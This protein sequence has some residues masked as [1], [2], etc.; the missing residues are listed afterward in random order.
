M[1]PPQPTPHGP[2]PTV[3][4]PS[5]GA[6]PASSSASTG[7]GQRS[8]LRD[9]AALFAE[10]AKREEAI[11]KEHAA[12]GAAAEREGR[13]LRAGVEERFAKATSLAEDDY[14]GA[15]AGIAE[16]H[17][18][19]AS[20]LKKEYEAEK[21]RIAAATELEERSAV[22][23]LKDRTWAAE[24]I[25]EGNEGKPRAEFEAVRKDV[26]KRLQ[27]HTNIEGAAALILKEYRQPIQPGEAGSPPPG[28]T[29]PVGSPQEQYEALAAE[30]QRRTQ[31]LGSR[32]L[33][34]FFSNLVVPVVVALLL[35][36]GAAAA[37][38]WRMAWKPT[39]EV[40][41]AGGG[42]L[43]LAAT[44]LVLLARASR[45]GVRREREPLIWLLAATRAAA[46]RW[47]AYA[48][49][50]RDQQAA[51]LVT[52]R[53]EEVK[54]AREKYEPLVLAAR[55][56]RAEQLAVITQSYTTQRAELEGWR[57]TQTASGAA[58]RRD[59][60]EQSAAAQRREARDAEASYTRQAQEARE[61]HAAA[62]AD[63]ESWWAAGLDRL[64]QQHASIADRDAAR[65]PSWSDPSWR[66]WRGPTGAAPD[67]PEVRF[68]DITLDLASLPGGLPR[69]PS[70]AQPASTTLRLPVELALP[71]HA[72]VFL[73][74]GQKGAGASA[75]AGAGRAESIRLLR[76]LMLRLLLALPPGKAR[77]TIIDPVGLGESFA[78]FMHLA[79]YEEALVGGKIWTEARHIEQRLVDLTE[80]MENVIQKYLRNEFRTIAEYNAQA[81]EIAEPY[82]FLVIADFPANFNEQA[83]ARLAAVCASGARCGV[84]TLIAM[85]A[86]QPTPNGVQVSDLERNSTRL[87]FR[88][89]RFVL[90]DKDFAQ[91]PLRVDEPPEEDT[92]NELVHRIGVAAKDSGRVQVPFDLIAPSPDDL[93]SGD[94]TSDLRVPLGRAGA[95][96][97]QYLTLGRGT[98]Q[99]M[100]IAGKTGSG[101]STLL[102]TI[103]TNLAMWFS[104]DEV[105][106]YLVDFKKGVEFKSYAAHE[107]PHARAVAIESD[108]EFGLS[109]LQRLDVELKRRG[110]L[111]RDLGVQDLAGFRRKAAEAG[112]PYSNEKLPRTLLIID[113]FQEFFTEDDKLAQDAT[114]L[115][116]RLVRQG[117]AFGIHILLGSQT[118]SGAYNLARS[119]MGQMGVRIAL[120]CSEADSYLILSEDNAAA[121]LLSRPGEAIYN[122]ASGLVEGN[123]PFQIA[124]L[125]DEQRDRYLDRV[126]AKAEA[127]RY[128]TDEPQS[129][130]EGNVP[131]D[132][133]RNRPLVAATH[134][135]RPAKSPAAVRIW[136]GD[137][138]AIKDPTAALL[139]RQT[140]SN[141]LIAGQ[142]DEA[143][144]A[145]MAAG[146]IGIG[147]QCSTKASVYVIDS[148]PPDAPHAGYL[149]RIAATLPQQVRPV[150]MRDIGAAMSELAAELARRQESATDDH[151]PVFLFVHGIQRCR[152]LRKAED[153]FSFSSDDSGPKPDKQLAEL[154][155]EGPALGMHTIVWCDTAGNAS[156]ALDR[157]GLKEFDWRALFQMSSTDSSMLIDTP[158][159]GKLGLHRALLHSE[160]Q[161]SAEK[162]RPYAV[163]DEAWAM[164]IGKHFLG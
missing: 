159:A 102:H 39:P 74:F 37:A 67:A 108:R 123:S 14:R 12:A 91:L 4:A 47:L 69:L 82:R 89:G 155:R 24:T 83:A 97:L 33:P 13:A 128:H 96:K 44:I 45:A 27:E 11:Q 41:L 131:S 76:T 119:T 29:D 115:L 104:P 22:K 140:A 127:T 118:L 80:H 26:E 99:H 63:L 137:A 86:R 124:W 50:K 132:L 154:L 164:D 163:P 70:L 64:Q 138:I 51:A 147:A 52:R 130:F 141:L 111:Y 87:S 66:A 38:T 68:G 35:A 53:D 139:R 34:R 112:P 134:A 57:E 61:R 62:L 7:A 152:P 149:E 133:R 151:E 146:I 72:S 5:P 56:K 122:D 90:D 59:A 103:I 40:A 158:E 93:W 106:F 92:F 100:L 94:T 65:F 113:E 150:A 142:R 109:V 9:A 156:R 58:R 125:S 17:A 15:S 2:A 1:T 121:R 48:A 116:D 120:Q 71:D 157:N 54:A 114:L 21:S 79:D 10:R 98:A 43:I 31:T 36:G 129:V 16:R 162:F 55:Q 73:K 101:K 95:T 78:G 60:L 49:D 117:R 3:A 6:P 18:T 28:W 32:P 144:L 135:P 110:N 143:A 30:S 107:L 8:L 42:T 105:N 19:E 161:G 23:A 77:F 85:D 136:L 126:T 145:M 75:P 81:G 25:Y 160:E 46:E 148:T 84:H 20:R 88:E 153:D